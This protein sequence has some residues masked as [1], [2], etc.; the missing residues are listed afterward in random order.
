MMGGPCSVLDARQH[1]VRSQACTQV[2]LGLAA[3]ALALSTIKPLGAAA[4]VK[5][6][7]AYC[8]CHDGVS[9]LH[10]AQSKQAGQGYEPVAYSEAP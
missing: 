2:L 3:I 10:A 1:W 7:T 9:V 5:A 6:N 8:Y 4:A